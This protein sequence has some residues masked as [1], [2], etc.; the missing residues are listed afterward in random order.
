MPP[1]SSPPPPH[2]GPVV[3]LRALG[4]VI[5]FV[6]QM[7][8]ALAFYRDALG[9]DVALD[10]PEWVELDTTGAT[11]ALH[12]GVAPAPAGAPDPEGVPHVQVSFAVASVGAAH[13]AL[14]SRGVVFVHG[15]RPIAPGTFL[16][17]FRDPDGH[18]LAIAGPA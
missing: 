5:L 6:T 11:L 16:A 14:S 8:R 13:A 3:P 18:S 2:P 17:R 7:P 10:T 9:L 4:K 12:A 15:P 1:P